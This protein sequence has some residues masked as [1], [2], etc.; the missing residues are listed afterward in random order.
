ML[1][2]VEFLLEGHL[3][4][5]TIGEL[6][7]SENLFIERVL[8][9]HLEYGQRDY[10]I[11]YVGVD[12]QKEADF[13]RIAIDYLDFFL[14]IH[15]L[16]SGQSVT[17]TIGAGTTLEDLSSLGAKRITFANYER[18]HMLGEPHDDFLKPILEIKKH[19]LQLL[20]DRQKIME[21][22]LG[23]A[24]IYWYFAVLAS[25]RRLEEAV[26]NLMIA[27][28]A[29]LITKNE[30]IRSSLSRRLSSLIGKNEMEIKMIA[31]EMRRL[32][33]LRS[34]IVHGRREKPKFGD[35]RALFSYVQ[36][37][38]DRALSLRDF[39]KERLVEKIDKEQR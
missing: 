23:L 9:K 7:V 24:M 26:I 6:R 1:H 32:Y 22:H 14:L 38:I 29:L 30:R 11:A 21:S 8:P 17:S 3:L 34:A 28:E 13:F 35:V 12:A 27:S 33:D 5:I 10:A 37:A 4:P 19:F 39:T 31:E 16:M 15:S 18:I 25:R 2:Q 36:R 20:P